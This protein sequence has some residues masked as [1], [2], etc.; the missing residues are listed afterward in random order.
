MNTT[1][2]LL[3]T[4]LALATPLPAQA[5]EPDR[6]EIRQTL[7]DFFAAARSDDIVKFASLTTPDFHAFDG[8]AKFAGDELM[9]LIV[10]KHAEGWVFEW[11]LQE[12][13]IGL[14]GD[15]AWASWLN[16]GSVREPGGTATEQTWQ[17]SAFL[18]R[19]EGR[20]LIEFFHSSRAK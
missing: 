7:Q 10:R 11:N 9:R 13:H 3:V 20:W 14:H 19:R 5:Q 18:R 1:R 6:A 17:E 4:L 15:V 16:V 12:P 8:G 2:L